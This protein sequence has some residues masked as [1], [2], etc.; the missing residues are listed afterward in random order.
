MIALCHKLIKKS[1]PFH[2]VKNI[3]SSEKQRIYAFRQYEVSRQMPNPHHP[4]SIAQ[5]NNP[6]RLLAQGLFFHCWNY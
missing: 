2:S 1:I 6:W 4:S 5:K 3:Y